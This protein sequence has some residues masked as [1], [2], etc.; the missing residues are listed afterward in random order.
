MIESL[1]VVF[2][3]AGVVA[4]VA[5]ACGVQH[6]VEAVAMLWA[7]PAAMGVAVCCRYIAEEWRADD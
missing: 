6:A 1:A 4:M 2:W 7:L 3:L 5:W